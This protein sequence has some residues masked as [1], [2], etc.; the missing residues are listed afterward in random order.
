MCVIILL[1]VSVCS[2]RRDLQTFACHQQKQDCYNK[3]DTYMSDMKNF[4]C[5][6]H[7]LVSTKAQPGVYN[8]PFHVRFH[9]ITCLVSLQNKIEQ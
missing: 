5:K 2:V 1:R 9:Y 7:Y 8:S 3:Q 4:A 6:H